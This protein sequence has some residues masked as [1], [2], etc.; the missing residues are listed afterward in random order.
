MGVYYTNSKL[1]TNP[2]LIFLDEP[3]TGLD[4]YTAQNVFRLLKDLAVSGRTVVLTIHQPSSEIFEIFDQLMLMAA[5]KVI[6]MNSADRAVDYFSSIGYSWPEQ[7]NPAD[8]FMELMSIEALQE[9]DTDNNEELKRCQALLEESYQEKINFLVDKYEDSE[10][11]WDSTN[12]NLFSN[13]NKLKNKLD[14]YPNFC[15][16]FKLLMQ[17][18]FLGMI[19][20]PLASYIQTLVYIAVWIVTVITYG[21]LGKNI[22]SIQ[23]RNGLLFFILLIYSIISY[24]GVILIFPEERLIFLK[25]L[26]SKMYSKTP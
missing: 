14:Y 10:L 16:Q 20:V 7:T 18:S 9:P 26:K 8:Y 15:K 5:G 11:K 25:E 13:L 1:I 19:R 4:S 12:S 17:R 21:Q 2:R 22:Q 23:N 6:Y 24:S 3:T